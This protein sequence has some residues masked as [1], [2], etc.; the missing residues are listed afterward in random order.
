M[1]KWQSDENGSRVETMSAQPA[2]LPRAEFG[3]GGHSTESG[4]GEAHSVR[5]V[6]EICRG[7]KTIVEGTAILTIQFHSSHLSSE[8]FI[9]KSAFHLSSR[10]ELLASRKY[11]C[12]SRDP[13]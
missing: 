4:K 13:Q 6:T 7:F 5:V 1:L 8:V 12:H 9:K 10:T 3:I 2:T 11:D